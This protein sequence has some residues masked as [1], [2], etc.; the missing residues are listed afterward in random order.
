MDFQWDYNCWLQYYSQ[1]DIYCVST[2]SDIHRRISAPWR[3]LYC[4]CPFFSP[5][6]AQDSAKA[7]R[8]CSIGSQR[9]VT[10]SGQNKFIPTVKSPTKRWCIKNLGKYFQ[11]SIL[12]QV[13]E[14]V[15]QDECHTDYTEECKET[16]EEICKTEFLT[17][18]KQEYHEICNTEYSTE[19][20]TE[21]I[22]VFYID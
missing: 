17:D 3:L 22:Q 12:L 11:W 5:A 19:C 2:T 18:C 20:K 10:S 14:E 13:C 9:S 1:W 7:S 16:F 4:S 15:Y 21:Y 8:S 6:K